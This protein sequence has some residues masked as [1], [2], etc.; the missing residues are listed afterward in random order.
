[1]ARRAASW[2]WKPHLDRE[3]AST[4][5]LICSQSRNVVGIL[6]EPVPLL[7]CDLLL[8]LLLVPL[9]CSISIEKNCPST[10][11]KTHESVVINEHGHGTA[12][13]QQL[14]VGLHTAF[15]PPPQP[16]RAPGGM[17]HGARRT[18]IQGTFS[19]QLVATSHCARLGRLSLLS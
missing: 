1:M 19:S 16:A 5:N 3:R 11:S 8:S 2:K 18:F 15:L 17:Q 10:D 9:A 7:R 4:H 12:L 14:L 13:V 6:K